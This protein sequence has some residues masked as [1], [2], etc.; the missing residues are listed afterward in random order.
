VQAIDVLH[1]SGIVLRDLQASNIII[2]SNSDRGIARIASVKNAQLLGPGQSVIG[3]VGDIN[4]R[5]PEVL[6]GSPYDHKADSWSLGVL[7][8]F[9]LT[10]RT[11][12]AVEEGVSDYEKALRNAIIS[13][14]PQL[15]VLKDLGFSD[16]A[17]DL[18]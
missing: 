10:Q 4:Y 13:G 17:F 6:L 16:I 5:A 14:E 12:W 18:V 8:Y 1:D 2:T 15:Q 9:I 3:I 7:I 11:P